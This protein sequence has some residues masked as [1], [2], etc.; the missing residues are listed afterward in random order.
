MG[1]VTPMY[2]NA[3]LPL[4]IEQYPIVRPSVPY[5]TLLRAV[6]SLRHNFCRHD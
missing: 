1:A 2:G 6:L 3:L 4:T 5:S